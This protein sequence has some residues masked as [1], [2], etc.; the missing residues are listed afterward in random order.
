MG[1]NDYRDRMKQRNVVLDPALDQRLAAAAR[2]AGLS[3]NQFVV[4]LIEREVAHAGDGAGSRG[5]GGVAAA[6]FAAGAVGGRGGDGYLE[7]LPVSGGSVD[8][9]GLLER[10]RAAK[11]VG[12]VEPPLF[13]DP[14]PL[15]VIA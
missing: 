7:R 10:G 4:G 6:G 11:L 3:V 13:D 5:S 9:D 15:D 1:R 14:D 12:A 2:A 8:W